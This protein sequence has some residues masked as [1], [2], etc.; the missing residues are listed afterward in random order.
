MGKLRHIIVDVIPVMS[1]WKKIMSV[2]SMKG[3]VQ[4]I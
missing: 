1:S 3:K 4:S 2:V